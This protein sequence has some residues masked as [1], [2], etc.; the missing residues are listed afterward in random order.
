[1][2]IARWSPSRS[3][4]AFVT[5]A[6]AVA[7]VPGTSGPMVEQLALDDNAPALLAT[8]RVPPWRPRSAPGEAI[9][10]CV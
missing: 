4:L 6:E 9:K 5:I 1:M 8:N 7:A 3:R 10:S 2:G